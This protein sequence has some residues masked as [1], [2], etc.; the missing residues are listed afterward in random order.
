MKNAIQV[1]AQSFIFFFLR[2]QSTAR[3][4]VLAVNLTTE[5]QQHKTDHRH[6]NTRQSKCFTALQ[7]SIITNF[8][9]GKVHLFFLYTDSPS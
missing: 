7:R 9:S 2:L 4:N 5:Q 8:Y 1:V 3:L 6:D